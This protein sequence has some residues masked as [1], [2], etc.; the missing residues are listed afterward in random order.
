MT[1]HSLI[2]T[3]WCMSTNMSELLEV[4]HFGIF[5]IFSPVDY[6][7][8]AFWGCRW[9]CLH[10]DKFAGAPKSLFLHCAHC[11]R[12]SVVHAN[13]QRKHC[14]YR[15]PAS[16]FRDGFEERLSY[17]SFPGSNALLYSQSKFV[18]AVTKQKEGPDQG[19]GIDHRWGTRHRSSPGQRVCQAGGQK[20]NF[21]FNLLHTNICL[22]LLPKHHNL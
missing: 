6:L 12:I 11:W 22:P 15:L 20:G 8:N 5:N 18:F 9:D 13:L 16:T 4:T 14:T 19:G 2:S 7:C 21:N 1:D 3:A 17:V 10:A